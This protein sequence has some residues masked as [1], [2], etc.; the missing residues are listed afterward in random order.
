M[1]LVYLVKIKHK[2][3]IRLACFGSV[4]GIGIIIYSILIENF[5]CCL[6]GTILIGSN[7]SLGDAT[8]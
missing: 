5:V 6:I 1:N 3:R 4:A 7:C 8:L 2:N